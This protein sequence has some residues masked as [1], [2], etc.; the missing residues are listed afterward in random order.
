MQ[1][2][3]SE[4]SLQTAIL[5]LEE[6]RRE[7]AKQL[8]E[9]LLLALESVKPINMIK[10]ALKEVAASQELQSRIVRT[11]L[12]LMTGYLFQ[13][14]FKRVSQNRYKRLLAA[15]L[16]FGITTAIVK[17]P[18]VVKVIGNRILKLI[19]PKAYAYQD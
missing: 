2:I 16:Q 13:K 15:A 17:N 18:E 11:A 7:E 19:R 10:S 1:P 6:K 8:T 5:R 14:I 12:A 9:H 4:S 3:N